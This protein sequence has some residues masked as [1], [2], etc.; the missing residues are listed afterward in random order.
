MG[1][2]TTSQPSKRRPR[3]RTTKNAFAWRHTTLR[4]IETDDAF[5]AGWTQLELTVVKPRK[6]PVPLT[7]TGYFCHYLD[8]ETLARVGGPV[9]LFNDWLDREPATKKWCEAEFRWRQLD[10]FALPPRRR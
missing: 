1:A 7:A 8:A 9:Q 10:L 5:E 6:A 4:I 3:R 2:R